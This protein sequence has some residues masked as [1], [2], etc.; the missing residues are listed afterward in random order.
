MGNN[1]FLDH[2]GNDL[3]PSA[4]TWFSPGYNYLGRNQ[5]NS[6]TRMIWKYNYKV[7]YN[8]NSVLDLIPSDVSESDLL[9]VKGRALATRANA[10]ITL[11]RTYANGNLGIPYYSKDFYDSSRVP[12]DKVYELIEQDLL[13]A[14]NLL[15]GFTPSSKQMINDNVVAGFLSRLY[16]T[17]KKYPDA[18][19]YAK[20]AR[21][22]RIP[23]NSTQLLDGFSNI[24]NS[25][26]MWGADIDGSSSTGYASFFSHMDNTNEGYAGL[27]IGFK[28]IDQRLYDAISSTD[29]RKEWLVADGQVIKS[30]ANATLPTLA[31]LKFRDETFFLGDYVFMRAAE[32]YLNEAE[33]SVLAGDE[34]TARQVL[35][36]LISTRDP[37]Y[38]LSTNSGTLLLDEIKLHRRIELWVEGFSLFDMKR[39]EMPLER[40]YPGS[41]QRSFGKFNYP[42]NSPKFTLQIPVEEIR[43]NK[44]ITT[45]NPL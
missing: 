37:Q 7:I 2:M 39:W 36:E 14:Y 27:G 16:L 33:A 4:S 45:Q 41:N 32:M 30:I 35:F 8:M 9:Y 25:E 17:M 38:T 5:K 20:L 42:A 10:Y 6:R 3:V 19:K 44:D 43:T 18:A 26:W 40:D 12:T 31:N 11:I 21:A 1:L 28:L 23:M 22:G 15:Q 24:Q 13:E 29:L 34:G